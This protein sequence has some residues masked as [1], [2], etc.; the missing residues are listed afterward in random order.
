MN[1]MNVVAKQDE[2]NNKRKL[3]DTPGTCTRKRK[4]RKARNKEKKQEKKQVED[5]TDLD[6]QPRPK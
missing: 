2:G 1:K 4:R 6:K 5:Y 3:E